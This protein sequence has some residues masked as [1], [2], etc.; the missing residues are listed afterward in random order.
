MNPKDMR[1]TKIRD[2]P[3]FWMPCFPSRTLNSVYMICPD[4]S[5]QDLLGFV[6]VEV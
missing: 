3:L 6:D 1:V 2:M 4:A 5:F